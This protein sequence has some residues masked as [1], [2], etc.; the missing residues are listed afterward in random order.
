LVDYRLNLFFERGAG[1]VGGRISLEEERNHEVFR[2]FLSRIEHGIYDLSS[3][4]FDSE[5][6]RYQEHGQSEQP[7]HYEHWEQ[8]QQSVQLGDIP[9]DTIIASIKEVGIPVFTALLGAYL[10]AKY[11][12]KIRLKV[13]DIEIETSNIEEV[14]RMIVQV[15]T[16]SDA[17]NR[18][19]HKKPER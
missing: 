6:F 8:Q 3:L 5:A 13:N 18:S 4:K 12:R 15:S 19:K 1:S 17:I 14:E 11:R 16:L 9:V 10:Q 2:E 7:Q